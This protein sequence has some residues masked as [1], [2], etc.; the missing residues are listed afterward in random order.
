MIEPQ[1]RNGIT[2]PARSGRT[3]SGRTALVTAA[4]SVAGS[5]A[6]RAL[7]RAGAAL[8]LAARDIAALEVLVT[9]VNAAGG[10]ASAV[11]V[12]ITDPAS[13][14]R[15]TEQT[16][17]AFGRLDAAVNNA[18]GSGLVL[19]MRYQVLAMRRLGGGCIV[20]LAPTTA[21]QITV[22]EQSR[23]AVVDFAG[24]GVRINVVAG[25]G[26]ADDVA[27]AV[28][29]LCSDEASILS[30]DTLHVRPLQA[31]GHLRGRAGR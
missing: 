13:V 2:Q 18:W 31:N 8:V 6:S 14:R 24:S 17:G 19:A 30:G 7:G 10:H 26:S 29:W 20:N 11:P 27:E 28:A 15:L 21:A 1:A 9:E 22:A 16:L 23:A 4:D 3:L 25:P 12:D 5:A